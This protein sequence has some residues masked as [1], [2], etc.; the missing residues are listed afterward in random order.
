MVR[1]A[2]LAA[3]L[4]LAATGSSGA[5][6]LDGPAAGAV[7]AYMAGAKVP[8]FRKGREARCTI[9][10]IE[11]GAVAHHLGR[12]AVVF[13]PY[14]FDEEGLG[15]DQMIL[16]FED[17]V[18]GWSLRGK[19]DSTQGTDPVGLREDADGIAYAGRVD[20]EQVEGAGPD[21]RARFRIRIRE[22]GVS[23]GRDDVRGQ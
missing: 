13:V 19:V 18:D 10:A 5:S 20:G 4:W 6:R 14:L 8:C 12:Y 16:V 11:L 17:G 22:D 7:A 3:G 23:F 21:G 15:V 2:F 9:A 1:T